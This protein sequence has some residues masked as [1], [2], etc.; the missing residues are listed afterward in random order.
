MGCLFSG[1]CFQIWEPAFSWLR[2]PPTVFP[3]VRF[4][5]SKSLTFFL[6]RSSEKSISSFSFAYVLLSMSAILTQHQKMLKRL[7]DA[8]HRLEQSQSVS[9]SVLSLVTDNLQDT[10]DP[11]IR[12]LWSDIFASLHRIALQKVECE[13]ELLRAQIALKQTHIVTFANSGSSL[14][15]PIQTPESE[16]D[17]HVFTSFTEEHDMKP[18]QSIALAKVNQNDGAK[19]FHRTCPHLDRL[20]QNYLLAG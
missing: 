16:R 11:L 5:Q 14:A 4:P 1:T 6:F 2:V 12:E 7:R 19:S 3:C 13:T 17:R 18:I 9:Q 8:L 15:S 10:Q 20:T